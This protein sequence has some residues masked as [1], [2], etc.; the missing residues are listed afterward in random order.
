MAFTL[1]TTSTAQEKAVNKIEVKDGKVYVNGEMVKELEDADRPLILLGENTTDGHAMS[2]FSD[3]NNAERVVVFGRS[4]GTGENFEL[5]GDHKKM[6]EFVGKG[7]NFVFS[8]AHTN[9]MNRFELAGS[10]FSSPDR[11]FWQMAG[12][13]NMLYSTGGES[14]EIRQLEMKS[15]E[16][17]RLY[18]NAAETERSGLADDLRRI[19][20][21]IFDL[22]ESA[23]TERLEKMSGELAK[24]TERVEERH[25][26]KEDIISRRYQE[27][28]GEKDTLAW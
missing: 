19:L 17:A 10:D 25:Q 16:L 9:R 8:G 11:L 15:H 3:D 1:V 12:S 21:K 24:L 13:N 14:D 26:T 28:V 5:G 7:G 27:L 2:F 18:R 22:K 4:A 23:M 6:M 20:E